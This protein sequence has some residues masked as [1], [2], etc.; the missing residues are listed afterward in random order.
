MSHKGK[1]N[2]RV[3]LISITLVL[4]LVIVGSNVFVISVLGY[5]VNSGQSIKEKVAGVNEVERTLYAHRG[6]ITDRN[7]SVLAQDVI[8]YRL[9]ANVDTTRFH[10]NGDPA[11]VVDKE[12]AA[13][14]IAP[15]LGTEADVVLGYLNGSSKQVEFAQYGKDLDISKKQALE[16]LGIAGLGFTEHVKR[17]YP[18]EPFAPNVVGFAGFNESESEIVG[19]FGIEKYFDK[20]LTGINGYDRYLQ[21][22]SKYKLRELE[23]VESVEGKDIKLTLDRSI[24]ESFEEAMEKI[25]QDPRV[26]T[27]EVWGAVMEAKTGRILAWAEHPYFDRNDPNTNWNS[28]LTQYAYEPGSTIKPFTIAA[29]INE[30]VYDRDELYN[31]DIFYAGIKDGKVIR[32]PSADGSVMTIN[33]AGRFR[34]GTIPFSYGFAVSSNVMISHLLTKEDGLDIEI[35]GDYLHKLGFFA[36]VEMD[37]FEEV[38]GFQLWNYPTEKLTT[39]YGQGS[40]VTMLQMLRAFTTVFG[41]GRIMNPY[42]VDSI[43]EPTSQE[44]LYQA[45]TQYGER[46]FSEE[47]TKEVQAAMRDVI[48]SGGAYHYNIDE[49]NV[50]GKTGTAQY[51]EAGKPGY[52]KSK[53][54]VSMVLGF[55]QED[56]E[57]VIYYAYKAPENTNRPAAAEQ[58]KNVM[59]QILSVYEFKNEGDRGKVTETVSQDLK[60]Y[61]NQPV[62]EVVDELNK[63]PYNNIVIGDGDVVVK[64]FPSG[65]QK[66][67]SNELVMLYTNSNNIKMPD[68]TGWSSKQVTNFWTLTKIQVEM[69]GSGFVVE[70]SIPAGT[71]LDPDSIIEVNLELEV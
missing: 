33:N 41:D 57:I 24:Q 17:N 28:R 64:Q 49:V 45:E 32:L 67:L 21:D 38:N 29:A 70:Q 68:M 42:I 62:S 7:G 61:V 59:R 22:G 54:I 51:V 27:D 10:A 23:R 19:Q 15:I 53:Y 40:T 18:L 37:R 66:V 58:I 2:L 50:I 48:L 39:G 11:H 65:N 4:A 1:G 3:M 26:D 71:T 36:P 30:G 44:V 9:Y 46:V 35:F 5:H 14:Q 8:S 55:P 31:S 47:T 25:S 69:I 20:E 16:G 13:Q 63:I 60:D 52:S 43:T 6:T 56:P 34:Q 12:A